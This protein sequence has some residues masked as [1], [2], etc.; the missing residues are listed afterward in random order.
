MHAYEQMLSAT[1]TDHAP[2]FIIPADHKWFTR[3]AIADLVVGAL[4]SLDLAFP[5]LTKA[6]LQGLAEARKRLQEQR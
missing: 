1:S 5:T 4:E 3:L 6:Q 2:W